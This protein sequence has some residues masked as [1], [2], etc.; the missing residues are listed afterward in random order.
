MVLGWVTARQ[1][2]TEFRRQLRR[3]WLV[4]CL[5]SRLWLEVQHARVH[6]RQCISKVYPP[7]MQVG[8]NLTF[9]PLLLLNRYYNGT[10]P[11]SSREN[12][13]RPPKREMGLQE[14]GRVVNLTSIRPALDGSTSW[15]RTQSRVS[16]SGV[17]PGLLRQV[18]C[19]DD[20]VGKKSDSFE[21]QYKG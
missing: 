7:P 13:S 3:K 11:L 14:L 15:T 18:T 19:L 2:V 8:T 21:T 9:V 6:L 1:H 17:G 20:A 16:S 4:L 12:T 10:W 5:A